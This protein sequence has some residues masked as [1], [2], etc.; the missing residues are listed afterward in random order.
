MV[1]G[2]ITEQVTRVLENIRGLLGS[3][4]LDFGN[5][6]RS[7]VFLS[8][9]SNFGALNDVYAKYFTKNPP[10]RSTVQVARLPKDALVEIEVVATR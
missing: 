4:G 7:T 2:G 6:V 5:V 10:A 3:Q 9:M 8:D 1:T